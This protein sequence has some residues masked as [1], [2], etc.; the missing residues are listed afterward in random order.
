M[1]EPKHTVTKIILFFCDMFGP[2]TTII[3][4]TVYTAKINLFSFSEK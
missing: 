4:N 1:G 3:S 2:N